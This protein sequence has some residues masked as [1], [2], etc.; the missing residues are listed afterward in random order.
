VAAF[1]STDGLDWKYSST[2][3]PY[4]ERRL[5]QEGP[6]ECDVVLLK[7]KKTL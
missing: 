1:T 5:W 4:D 7:D 6:N 2:A 3:G